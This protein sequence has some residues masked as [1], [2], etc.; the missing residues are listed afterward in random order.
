MATR[1]TIAYKTER[2]VTA[3]YCHWDGYPEG[4]GRTLHENYQAAYLI[5]KLVAHGDISSLGPEIGKQHS[6]DT[7]DG[8]DTWTTF[9]TR[10][11]GEDCPSK[12]FETIQEWMDYYDWSDYYYLWNGKEWLVHTRWPTSLSRPN[13][14]D[15]NGYPIFD[16]VEDVLTQPAEAC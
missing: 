15:E 5:G 3:I 1:S 4:V 2:G 13:N 7:R 8:E 16:R 14:T 11:R 9:Y 10:D 12:E 6:F